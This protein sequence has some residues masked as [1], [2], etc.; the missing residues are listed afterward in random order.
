MRRGD[1]EAKKAEPIDD[2]LRRLG[3]AED[4]IDDLIF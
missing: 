4:E 1:Q 3:I 2:M